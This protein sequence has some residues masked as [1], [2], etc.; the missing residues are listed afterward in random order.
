MN[1]IK[2]NDL[3]AK[4]IELNLKGKQK[5]GTVLGGCFSLLVAVALIAQL[6]ILIK[7]LV[8]STEPTSNQFSVIRDYD[9]ANW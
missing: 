8:L 7:K 9:S 6:V 1:F 5:Q 4:P 3:F 2:N